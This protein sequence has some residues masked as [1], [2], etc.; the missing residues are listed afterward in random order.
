MLHTATK[1]T[2]NRR[3]CRRR[4]IGLGHGC[5]SISVRPNWLYLL[6]NSYTHT[7][8]YVYNS[9]VC[10]PL[11]RIVR[12]HPWKRN[13]PAVRPLRTTITIITTITIVIIIIVATD[14][15]RPLGDLR[16]ARAYNIIGRVV[17]DAFFAFAT[18][19]ADILFCGNRVVMEINDVRRFRARPTGPP[20]FDIV[21]NNN[22]IFVRIWPVCLSRSRSRYLHRL[23]VIAN[24]AVAA[25]AA[26]VSN[27]ALSRNYAK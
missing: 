5:D 1:R 7:H 3:R 10:G 20:P 22:D 12:V 2:V 9:C 6:S 23:L 18:R 13:L 15:N 17:N 24:P 14:N 8:T 4:R 16:Y 26:A 27:N 25:A 11:N 19:F 21:I